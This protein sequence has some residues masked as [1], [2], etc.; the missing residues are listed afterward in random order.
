M[1]RV[2]AN[3]NSFKD[4]LKEVTLRDYTRILFG[5]AEIVMK[6]NRCTRSIFQDLS[7]CMRFWYLPHISR[8]EQKYFNIA[9]VL[10]DQ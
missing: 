5:V 3:K 6:G 1:G 8:R 7:Q 2:T 10:Q 9:L 4:G